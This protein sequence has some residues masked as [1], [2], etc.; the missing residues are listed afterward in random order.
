M[1]T[2]K[3]VIATHGKPLALIAVVMLL[4]DYIYLSMIGGPVFGPMVQ[5][6]Q[7]GQPMRLRYDAAAL[8][9]VV[10]VAG[11]YYFI[12]RQRR[13]IWEAAALGALVYLVY[14]LTNMATLT[15]YTWTAVAIDG[16]WGAILFALTTGIV[17]YF[18]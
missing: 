5:R 4:M 18:I 17:Y 14:D 10:M 3:T 11:L 7:R 12:I 6:I 16:A 8:V 13:S 9:Y 15:G 2:L 1:P